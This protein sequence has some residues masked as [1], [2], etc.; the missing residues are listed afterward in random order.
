MGECRFY[1]DL[2]KNNMNFLQ[3]WQKVNKVQE[4]VLLGCGVKPH[5]AGSQDDVKME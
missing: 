1:E 3:I 2:R 5:R 4:C